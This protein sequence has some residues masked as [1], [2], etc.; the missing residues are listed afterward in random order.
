MWPHTSDILKRVVALRTALRTLD[1]SD[2]LKHWLYIYIFDVV[3][4]MSYK[5]SYITTIRT[6]Y[7]LMCTLA[8]SCSLVVFCYICELHWLCSIVHKVSLALLVCEPF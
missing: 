7:S 1:E 2:M 8:A 5:H 6:L 4:A 3:G